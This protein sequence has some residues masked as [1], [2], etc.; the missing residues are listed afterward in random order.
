MLR[1]LVGDE[2]FFRGLQ[3]FYRTSR[4]TSSVGTADFR[5]AME[6]EAGRPLDRFFDRWIYGSK[7]PRLAFQLPR[8]RA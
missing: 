1:R 2:V 7:L 3:R 5:A 6:L 4:F 8:R